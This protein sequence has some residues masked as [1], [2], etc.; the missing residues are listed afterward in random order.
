MKVQFLQH[1]YEV[2]P[3]EVSMELVAADLAIL[4]H[5]SGLSRADIAKKLGWKKGRVTRILSGD[6][7]LT[8]K[9]ISQ[10]VEALGYTFDV[11]FYNKA[12]PKPKQPWQIDK[13]LKASITPTLTAKIQNGEQVFR[14]LL[15]GDDADCYVS[16]KRIPL[17]LQS[18]APSI[19]LL[20]K[21]LHNST[22][23]TF[24]VSIKDFAYEH[25]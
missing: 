8:I 2:E 25:N 1:V 11:V 17:N 20:K 24:S 18:N 19:E 10:F 23:Q 16:L 6:Q 5:H 12:Y 3:H 7:N 22:T 15:N 21:Q 4:L 13:A 9:T 14:D